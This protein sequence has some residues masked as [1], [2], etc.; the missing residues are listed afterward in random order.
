MSDQAAQSQIHRLVN[1]RGVAFFGASNNF[2]SMGTNML[3]SLLV[4]GFEGPIYPVHRSESV[5]LGHKAYRSVLDLP[6]APDL[7]VIVLPTKLVAETLEQCGQKGVRQAVICSGGFR[8]VGP[9]GAALERQLVDTAEKWGIRFVG[10]NCLGVVNTHHKLSTMFHS[11]N[12]RPGFVGMASQSGSFVTQMFDYLEPLGLGFSTCFSVGNSAN[13]D[14]V[15]CLEHLGDDPNTKVV[16]M[17]VEALSRGRRFVEVCRRVSQ[18]KPVVA[19]YVGG[20]ETGGKAGLSHTGSLA[21]PDA[22]YDGVFRQCGVVRAQSIEE[23]FDFCAVLGQCP[24]PR[25]DRVVI[26]THSGG[27]GAV[28]ADTCGRVGLKL[29]DLAPTTVQAL[30]PYIPVTGN[31][32]NPVDLTFSRSPMD[33]LKYIPEILLADENTDALLMYFLFAKGR[34]IS[35]QV[36]AGLSPEEAQRE[37]E[38]SFVEQSQAIVEAVRQSGKPFV[39][40]SFRIQ[41]EAFVQMVRRMGLPII[42]SP[43]RAA[44]AMAA[45]VRRERMRKKIAASI[46]AETETMAAA[47]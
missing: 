20:T 16:A 39:G 47:N 18:K 11:Y 17:Y 42:S 28:C 43:E 21:G 27:P 33:Y 8:E 31:V 30:A 15:D 5:V 12:G 19:Y 36:N 10:P 1:P 38:N 14:L 22:L 25:G 4:M 44:R 41:D 3:N 24:P 23:L 9:E 37:V 26:Q 7:A 32:N 40:F 46:A 13:V 35:Q 2:V 29:P 45:L 34:M 6:E